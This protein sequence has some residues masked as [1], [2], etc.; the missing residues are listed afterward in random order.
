MILVGN[1]IPIS[2]VRDDVAAAYVKEM[3]WQTSE[4]LLPYQRMC[5]Q[6][7]VGIFFIIEIRSNV[8]YMKKQEFDPLLTLNSG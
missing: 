5:V 2:R 3:E 4:M 6:R 7:K 1:L 8:D